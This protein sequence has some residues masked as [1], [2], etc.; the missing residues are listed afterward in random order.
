MLQCAFI[1][2][3]LSA[4]VKCRVS[5]H[6]DILSFSLY[7]FFLLYFSLFTF[8]IIFMFC[9]F[10]FHIYMCKQLF[11]SRIFLSTSPVLTFPFVLLNFFFFFLLFFIY[12]FF[13]GLSILSCYFET[14]S[15]FMNLKSRK[16]NIFTTYCN[17]CG[18]SKNR[19]LGRFFL[20]VAMSVY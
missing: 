2:H 20:V 19:P 3:N 4:T 18:F 6:P 12:I 5:G 7:F 1:L 11:F 13:W 8:I 16:G 9:N 17:W 15:F 14:R 10:V